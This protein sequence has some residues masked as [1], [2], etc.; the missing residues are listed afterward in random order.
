MKN[1]TKKQ[2]RSVLSYIIFFNNNLENKSA[3]HL[4]THEVDTSIVLISK[5]IEQCLYHQRLVSSKACI[6]KEKA[7]K[8]VCNL[9]DKM[10]KEIS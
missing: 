1:S 3:F 2:N 9:H 4:M 10:M 7:P 6:I 8:D 5:K